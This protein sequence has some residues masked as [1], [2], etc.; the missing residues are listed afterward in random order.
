MG[1]ISLIKSN[2]LRWD[3]LGVGLGAMVL[4]ILSRTN[5][6]Y[7]LHF[8]TSTQDVAALEWV[9][10]CWGYSTSKILPVV[11]LGPFYKLFGPSQHWETLLL[12]VWAA[13]TVATVYELARLISERRAV[14][15]VAALGIM[16]LPAFQYFSRTHLGY[17][18][19]FLL[20]GWLAAC[21]KRWPWVGLCFGLAITAHYNSWVPVGLSLGILGVLYCRPNSDWKQWVGLA[22][23]FALPLLAMDALFYI[24]TGVPFQWNQGVF[25]EVFRLSNLGDTAPSPNW[26]WVWQTL[27]ASNGLPLTVLLGVG[28]LAPI[29]LWRGHQT[30]AAMLATFVGVVGLYTFQGGMGRALLVSR[31]LATS[32]PFWMIGTALAIGWVLERI[33]SV[34]WQRATLAATSFILAIAILQTAIFIRAFTQTPYPY[35]EQ[36]MVRAAQESRPVRYVGIYWIPSFF[37]QV[38]GLEMLTGDDRWLND[39]A[40]GQAVLVFEG[41]VPPGISQTNYEIESFAVTDSADDVYLGLTYEATLPRQVEVWWPTR[42]SQPIGRPA[43]LPSY[44]VY[45]DGSGCVTMPAYG[46]Q[47]QWHFYEFAWHKLLEKLGLELK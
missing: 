42:A 44:S 31:I 23:C 43:H 45:F 13:V 8:D 24:Y 35:I 29:G 27:V 36:I 39:N 17:P 37:A 22:I 7:F 20:L 4:Q 33:R 10:D 34:V 25:G 12:L 3:W 16:A 18:M 28:W 26:G 14:G 30:G 1:A 15:L 9:R 6:A 5:S 41:R 47:R 40:P 32:Y 19:P 21:H 38:H 11:L 46:E 2:W